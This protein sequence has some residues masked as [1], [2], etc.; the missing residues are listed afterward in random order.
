MHNQKDENKPEGYFEKRRVRLAS[1]KI[2]I[3]PGQPNTAMT[4]EEDKPVQ[5]FYVET[6][7]KQTLIKKFYKLLGYGEPDY[8]QFSEEECKGYVGGSL[9]TYVY[10]YIGL[11][12]RLLLL[13]SGVVCIK[14]STKTNVIVESASSRAVLGVIPPGSGILE[15]LDSEKR[16]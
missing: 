14:V 12:S 7:E 5:N 16:T 11:W 2:P 15:V 8:P 3:E 4:S 6:S 10:S 1:K 13:V 9:G